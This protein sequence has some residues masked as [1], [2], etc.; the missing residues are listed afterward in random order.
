MRKIETRLQKLEQ[1]GPTQLPFYI[2]EGNPIPEDIGNR[3][4]VIIRHIIIEGGYQEGRNLPG[5]PNYTGP[6]DTLNKDAS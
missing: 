3:E 5:H 6:T 2:V 4:V 1:S